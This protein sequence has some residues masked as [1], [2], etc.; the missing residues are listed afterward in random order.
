MDVF[1]IEGGYHSIHIATGRSLAEVHLPPLRYKD[2][3]QRAQYAG[4]ALSELQAIPGMQ[5]TAGARVLGWRRSAILP[6][7]GR[8]RIRCGG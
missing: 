2:P 4:Q 7:A 6:A 1:E 8:P 5:G 3:E